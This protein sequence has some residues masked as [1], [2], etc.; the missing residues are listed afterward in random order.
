MPETPEELYR[1]AA[2]ALRMPPVEVWETFPFEGEIRPRPL[3]PPEAVERPRSGEG[4]VDC[5]RCAASDDEFLWTNEHWRLWAFDR[6][7]G[8]PLVVLL[9]SREH[10]SEPGD[11]RNE[12]AAELGILL[13]RIEREIR[14]LG[15]IGR[16]HV[17]RW[18]DGGEHL[19]WWFLARPARTPQ[20]IG[21]FAA[22]WDDIL[23]PVPEAVW[24]ADLEALA[25]ALG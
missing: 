24:R 6:P 1:R 5:G 25:A 15:N 7:T 20:L 11:L 8:L 18:G 22:I 21:S 13:A 3:L 19:H 14:A 23:P 10:Y 16:V 2:G 12:L 17:C 4:G 9:E